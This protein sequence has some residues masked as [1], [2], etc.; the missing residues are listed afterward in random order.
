MKTMEIIDVLARGLKAWPD[1]SD[2]AGPDL[3]SVLFS[4]WWMLDSQRGEW[5]FHTGFG[6]II[7]K[8]V[9]QQ[10][11]TELGLTHPMVTGQ[12]DVT[13]E[14]EEAWNE[15][16]MDAIGLNGEN[17]EIYE[18]R[19]AWDGEAVG[20]PWLSSHGHRPAR[21][22]SPTYSSWLSVKSRCR[23][24]DNKNY[25]GRGIRVCNRWW[26][27][28]EMFLEDMGERPEGCTVDRIDGDG[29]YEPGN[30][31]WATT[32][33]Q[34]ATRSTTTYVEIDGDVMMM[35][36]AADA[37]SIPLSTFIRR[38]SEGL[39]G[40]ELVDGRNRNYLRTGERVASS[41]LT[42]ERVREI[43]SRVRGGESQRAVAEDFGVRQPTISNIMSGVTWKGV[44]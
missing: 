23:D 27:S 2:S 38:Y 40:E 35:S 21:G 33:E 16:R 18:D 37:F 20:N 14:E 26:R 6:D 39:R 15:V 10:R 24:P 17:L 22:A 7:R 29:D 3:P 32:K 41:K 11:R 31:R 4:S 28:F 44:E 43:K 36:E 13:A 5:L 12:P 42:E 25:G 34:A 8:G 9:W 19:L 1:P 30:C